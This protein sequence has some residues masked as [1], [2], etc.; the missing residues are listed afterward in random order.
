MLE[1]QPVFS[2]ILDQMLEAQLPYSSRAVGR[3]SRGRIL[4]TVV[5]CCVGGFDQKN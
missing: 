2:T 3:N 4:V 1:P 5:N